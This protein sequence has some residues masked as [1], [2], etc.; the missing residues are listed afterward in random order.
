MRSAS[1]TI[2]VVLLLAFSALAMVRCGSPAVPPAPGLDAGKP[3]L[4]GRDAAMTCPGTQVL[5]NNACCADGQTCENDTCTTPCTP[6]CGAAVCG[7]D[8]ACG[9]KNCGECTTGSKCSG[10]ACLICANS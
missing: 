9:T 8:P 1:R 2:L 5:C 4:P 3:V 6:A 7:M 10:G